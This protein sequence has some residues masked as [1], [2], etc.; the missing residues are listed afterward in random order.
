MSKAEDLT[1]ESQPSPEDV[2]FLED[3]INTLNVQQTGRSDYVPLGIF[4][5]D[6]RGN[7]EAG[8]YGWTWG[9]SARSRRF[10]YKRPDAAR[11]WAS[12]S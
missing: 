4:V 5:R 3:R 8:V 1:L 7:V 2:Q 12:A 10:G 6:E 9:G 11:D